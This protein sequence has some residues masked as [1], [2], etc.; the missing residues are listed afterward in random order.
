MGGKTGIGSGDGAMFSMAIT[1]AGVQPVLAKRNASMT[2]LA[3]KAKS[4]L[5]AALDVESVVRTELGRRLR[6]C[7]LYTSPSPRD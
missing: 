6:S 2:W 4:S 1:E 7:L 3:S 5:E